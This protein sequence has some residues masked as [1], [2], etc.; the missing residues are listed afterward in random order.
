MQLSELVQKAAGELP[1][2]WNIRVDIERYAG[3][4]S[5]EDPDG[6]DVEL[7]GDGLIEENFEKALNKA[8]QLAVV[9]S[10]EEAGKEPGDARDT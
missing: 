2:G 7:A 1:E 9:D 3:T 4:V 5:L 6:N 10:H 8:L